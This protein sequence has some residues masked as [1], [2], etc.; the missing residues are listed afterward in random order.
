MCTEKNLTKSDSV[1]KAETGLLWLRAQGKA[2]MEKCGTKKGPSRKNCT[3]RQCQG[4]KV[5]R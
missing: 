2:L 3:K 1:T 4:A 5:C